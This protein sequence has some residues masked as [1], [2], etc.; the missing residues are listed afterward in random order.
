[1]SNVAPM[2]SHLAGIE[3]MPDRPSDVVA[4]MEANQAIRETY[5][6]D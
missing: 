3:S 4:C 2:F 1:M 6:G 5:W